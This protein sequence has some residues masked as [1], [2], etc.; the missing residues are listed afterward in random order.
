MTPPY[1]NFYIGG[2]LSLTNGQLN[3]SAV[4]CMG[5]MA[6]S[7]KPPAW[8]ANMRA[9]PDLT[10]EIGKRSFPAHATIVADEAERARPLDAPVAQL[11]WFAE[12]PEKA[13]R[14]IPMIRLTPTT[15]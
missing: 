7:T 5:R 13:Q 1:L 6:S 4:C 9:Y 11:P 14:P 12:Y 10:L 8:V 15:E 3:I 2:G